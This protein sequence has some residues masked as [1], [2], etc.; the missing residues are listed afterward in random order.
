[1]VTN[2]LANNI[3]LDQRSSTDSLTQMQDVTKPKSANANT[4]RKIVSIGKILST[5]RVK[6]SAKT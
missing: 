1:M 3:G 6:G 2:Q 5:S 4:R